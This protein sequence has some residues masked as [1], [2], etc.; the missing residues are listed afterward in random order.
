MTD[1]KFLPQLQ[2]FLCTLLTTNLQKLS[3]SWLLP[4][5][6]GIVHCNSIFDENVSLGAAA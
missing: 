1:F 4:R 5:T 3:T 2:K 6:V